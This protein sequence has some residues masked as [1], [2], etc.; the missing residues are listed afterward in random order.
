[1]YNRNEGVKSIQ[2]GLKEIGPTEGEDPRFNIITGK[3]THNQKGP[4][5]ADYW[6][7]TKFMYPVFD[8]KKNNEYLG[9]MTPAGYFFSKEKFNG[10]SFP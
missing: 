1:L 9:V 4:L 7:L 6:Y 10:W 3:I 8:E 2:A 5:K